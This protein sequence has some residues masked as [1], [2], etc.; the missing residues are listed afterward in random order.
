MGGLL[1]LF[2]DQHPVLGV[3]LG[4][5]GYAAALYALGYFRPEECAA[6]RQRIR[7]LTA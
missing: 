1:W 7:A 5:F 3:S 2:G 6:M 4:I